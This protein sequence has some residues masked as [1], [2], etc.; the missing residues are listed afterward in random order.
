MFTIRFTWWEWSTPHASFHGSFATVAAANEALNVI[1]D[2]QSFEG[3][4]FHGRYG[5]HVVPLPGGVTPKPL[6]DVS[7]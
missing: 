3:Q 5:L 2:G 1:L 7:A 6:D 4:S